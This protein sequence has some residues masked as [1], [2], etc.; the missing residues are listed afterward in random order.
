MAH[1]C[2]LHAVLYCVVYYYL[3]V[4]HAWW[5]HLRRRK[6]AVRQSCHCCF[7]Y[8]LA[9]TLSISVFS[10]T[11]VMVVISCTSI[12]WLCRRY[13]GW[14]AGHYALHQRTAEWGRECACF[15]KS[16][17]SGCRPP[18]EEMPQSGGNHWRACCA[19]AELQFSS[20]EL[21][22]TRGV[23]IVLYYIVCTYIRLTA[24]WTYVP[25]IYHRTYI[26]HNIY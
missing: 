10:L 5:L 16:R 20:A 4:S 11:I 22:C 26:G 12:V 19:A 1:S 8:C 3:Y 6:A 9:V 23:C 17:S 13:G 21:I 14:T 24:N 7:T 18:V 25:N 15:V 2:F